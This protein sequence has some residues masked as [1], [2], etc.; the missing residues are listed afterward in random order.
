MKLEIRKANKTELAAYVAQAI[1]LARVGAPSHEGS[2]NPT[3]SCVFYSRTTHEALEKYADLKALGWELEHTI[4]ALTKGL[5]EFTAR[6]SEELFQKD[7]PLI[8]AKAEAAYQ[9][10][11]EQHNAAVKRQEQQEAEVMAEFE[12]R[13]AERK[14]QLLAEV[15]ADLSQ[16]QNPRFKR[17]DVNGYQYSR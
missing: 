10:E 6:K 15:R 12:R 7:I 4:P 11:I 5:L 16:Q 17:S 14:A 1:Q 8:S 13:E 2:V 9:R 3:G